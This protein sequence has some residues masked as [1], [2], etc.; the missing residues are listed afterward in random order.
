MT[1][2]HGDCLEEMKKIPDGSVDLILTDPPYGTTA[3]KWDS[4]IPFEPMWNQLMR[5]IK[6]DRAIALFGSEPFSSFQRL[7]N[8]R[9][10]CYDWIWDKKFA[11]NFVQAKR[12]PLKTH[13]IIS[14]F[15]DGG[16][17]PR[18][19]PQMIDRDKP[20][21]KGGNKQSAAIPIAITEASEMFGA[22]GKE[23]SQKFPDSQLHFSVRE[24]RG[25]HP[26]QKPVSLLEYV[27][28]TYTQPDE[29]VLDFTMG[30]GSTGIACVNTGR[31]FIGIELDENY[32]HISKKRIEEALHIVC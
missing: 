24:S 9:S 32:Y 2:Y 25:L 4:V 31:R 16:K 29:V 15:C 22:V 3:C 19:F 17:M 10:F 6:P 26:T 30:S 5:V 13:E 12:Q 14:V 28:R 21:K 18:Y 7:S 11:G 27:I 8:I 1:L 20:I 23:Y